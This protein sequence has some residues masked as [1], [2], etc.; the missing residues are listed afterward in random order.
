VTL[1][2]GEAIGRRISQRS[3]P[4]AIVNRMSDV[5]PSLDRTTNASAATA[6]PGRGI[7][8][9]ALVLILVLA[10]VL[11]WHGIT[12]RGFFFDELWIAELSSGHGSDFFELPVNRLLDQPNLVALNNALPIWKV[13]AH[14]TGAIHPPGTFVMLRLWREVFG[15]TM[16][17][18]RSF[19]AAWSLVVVMLTFLATRM[20]FGS[21]AGLWA[22]LLSAVSTANIDQAQ[23][24]RGY[25]MLQAIL[26]LAA[27]ALLRLRD[28]HSSWSGA[29]LVGIGTLALMFTHYFAAGSCAVIAFG[30]IAL[31]RG[32]VRWQT[33]AAI[34][35]AGIIWCVMW[36][37]QLRSQL[38]FVPE[39]ADFFLVDKTDSPLGSTVLRLLTSPYRALV[40]DVQSVTLT[41]LVGGCLVLYLVGRRMNARAV[42][43]G[44]AIPLF[45]V[46]LVLGAFAPLI[47]LDLARHTRH[48]DY[49]KYLLLANPPL[50]VLIGSLVVWRR[51][52]M[53]MLATCG[54]AVAMYITPLP[55]KPH[56]G[57]G[58]DFLRERASPQ[59]V[60]LMSAG[61]LKGN[62]GQPTYLY[63]AHGLPWPSHHIAIVAGPQ[64]PEFIASLPRGVRWFYWAY[65]AANVPTD[66]LPNVRIVE[67]GPSRETA[68]WEIA[69]AE[70]TRK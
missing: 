11:R 62:S 58:V 44:I 16:L 70:A 25:T 4:A 46:A 59:D 49:M 7:V 12:A 2:H 15:D 68:I 34:A 3:R 38:A 5:P 53:P 24:V 30:A 61:E 10:A 42:G 52:L 33:L 6:Q 13:P 23:D 35:V 47:A 57:P 37:P 50:C 56:F 39:T 26:L 9:A 64:S 45:W 22:A 54:L 8:T 31:L 65:T 27:M 17:A 28:R 67:T 63:V 41:T 69:P 55:P 18:L 29:A 66:W 32:K 43:E 14:I 21:T 60:I 1:A 51:W 19:S 36:L 48:L 40:A 20:C